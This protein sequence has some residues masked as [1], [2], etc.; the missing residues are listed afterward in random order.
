MSSSLLRDGKCRDPLGPWLV[1][2]RQGQKNGNANSVVD[3]AAMPI[4]SGNPNFFTSP[5]PLAQESVMPHMRDY[6]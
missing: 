2:L 6:R 1:G 3:S 5:P 4:A